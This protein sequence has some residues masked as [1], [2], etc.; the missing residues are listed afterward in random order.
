MSLHLLNVSIVKQFDGT[1][2]DIPSEDLMPFNEIPSKEEIVQ[3]W[4][5]EGI[6]VITNARELDEVKKYIA[7][8]L[9]DFTEYPRQIRKISNTTDEILS[10]RLK[11]NFNIHSLIIS[12][13]ARIKNL[14][15]SDN[16]S[17]YL[18][19][20]DRRNN[21]ASNVYFG[22][23]IEAISKMKRIKFLNEKPEC[24]N[25]MRVLNFNSFPLKKNSRVQMEFDEEK[26]KKIRD[27]LCYLQS[28]NTI[29]N[30]NMELI[31]DMLNTS[32]LRSQRQIKDELD[33]I[34]MDNISQQL[35]SLKKGEKTNILL[36]L[37]LELQKSFETYSQ[38]STN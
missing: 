11:I 22:Y 12:I 7:W 3:F 35:S 25:E 2:A 23:Q 15:F 8:E 6:V 5:T 38:N 10:D 27:Y 36:E 13:G 1:L 9:Y 21:C 32:N 33:R 20:F 18:T 16:H 24:I 4:S 30:I 34:N 28:Q 37:Q 31:N 29:N 14:F 19:E 26:E 17:V